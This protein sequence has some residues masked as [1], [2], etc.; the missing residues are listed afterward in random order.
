MDGSG[1]PLEGAKERMSNHRRWSNELDIWM[2]FH[3]YQDTSRATLKSS[4]A[5]EAWK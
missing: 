2:F 4:L 1:V 3:V 5:S